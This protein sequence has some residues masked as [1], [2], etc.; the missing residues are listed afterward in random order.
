MDLKFETFSRLINK[1]ISLRDNEVVVCSTVQYGFSVVG[2]T[3][4]SMIIVP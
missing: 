4:P 3:T 1:V 2:I